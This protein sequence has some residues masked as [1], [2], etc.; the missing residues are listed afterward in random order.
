MSATT[1]S[2]PPATAPAPAPTPSS[3]A[4]RSRPLALGVIATGLMMTV[5]DGSIVTVAMPAIQNDLGFTPAG[6]SW[7]VNAYLIAF[8]GL[9]LLSGRLGDL[10]GRRRMFLAGTAV[11]TAASVLAGAAG[12][13]ALLVTARF[14]QGA[15]SAMASAVGLGILVTLFTESRERA[16]AIAVFSFTGAAGASIGQVLGGVLTDALGWHWIFFINLP[17]GLAV[18]LVAVRVLPADRGPGIAAGADTI[19]AL[20]V[21]GGVMLG[22]YSVVEVESYGWL[23]A[24][25]LGLGALALALLAAFVVRQATAAAPL[26]P[27][28]ILRSRSVAGANLVQI[29]MVAALFSFQILVALY[30]QRVLGYGATATGL[31]MLPAAAVIGA[32]SLGLSARLSARF[33]DRSVLLLGLALLIGVL[34]LLTRLPVHAHYATDLLPVMFLA[35]GFGLALPALTALGMSG[36]G[37]EDAG[38]ASGLFNTTQQIG[39]AMGVAVLSTLA[40]SR[41]DTLLAAGGSRAEALTG[42]YHL[43]FAAG[44]GLL[45]TAFLVALAVLGRP[46]RAPAA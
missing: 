1:P 32:V 36:A 40:A 18:L 43:A 45:A 20:L 14:L 13:P 16:R 46:D 17:I 3:P 7:V 19:G 37:E 15:G 11:F 34:G 33:G 41:T 25:T 8:G 23:S 31:A 26:L 42:G 2:S 10:L 30:L 35:A 9:L 27:L 12:S 5:L 39:M 44:T 28:R 22:I 6:L 38:L 29:L 4:A 21:T 24:H